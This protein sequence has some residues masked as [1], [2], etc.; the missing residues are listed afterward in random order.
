ML[1]SFP[2][3]I[4]AVFTLGLDARAAESV[5]PP[6]EAD[7]AASVASDATLAAPVAVAAGDESPTGVAP[8]DPEAV[9][10][11]LYETARLGSDYIKLGEPPAL[12]RFAAAARP[13]ARGAFLVLSTAYDFVG[14]DALVAAALA[15]LPD[16]G[17]S[18]LA[19][20]MPLATP[21][22]ASVN[23]EFLDRALARARAGIAHLGAAA[24]AGTIVVARG[25]SIA[26]AGQ[27]VRDTPHVL[28]W[29]TLG[30]WQGDLVAGGPAHFDLLGDA[31]ARA[32]AAF[33]ARARAAT[34]AG[35][36]DYRQFVL[37]GADRDF[38]SQADEV[39][40]RLQG[41]AARLP[42]RTQSPAALALSAAA[43]RSP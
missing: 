41:W 3:V 14:V 38:R 20:Q 28:G 19:V 26:V 27:L 32:Q 29:A 2:L 6:L 35:Q 31:D 24:A 36:P 40:A 33:A 11:Q 17:W 12:A 30:S 5:A 43:P 25:D 23:A 16:A 34:Q 1:N 4:C 15:R 13:Q 22:A 7:A 10:W 21:H 42:P 8:A 37:A 9:L 18:V 39:I